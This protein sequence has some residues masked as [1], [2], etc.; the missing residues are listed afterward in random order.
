MTQAFDFNALIAFVAV[1]D[2]ES[3][4]QAAEQLHLTQPAISKRVAALERD[5]DARLF[6][7]IGRGTY[8]T[9]AGRKLLP[10]AR[11]MLR[12]VMDIRRSISNLSGEV[13]GVLNMGTSHHIGLRRLPPLLQKYSQRFPQ[14]KLDIRFMDSE[15]ACAAV[16]QGDLELAVVTLPPDPSAHLALQEVWPD[17]LCFVVGQGHPLAKVR[18]AQLAQLADYPAVL[19]ARGT[20]TREILEQAMQ[21]MDLAIQISMTTNYLETLKMLTSI[22]LGWS[23]LPE[24]MTLD[25]DL[26]VLD[27]QGLRLNRS[28]GIVTH[29]QRSLSNA[30]R[31]MIAICGQ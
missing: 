24:T 29:R 13:M 19:A 8:L 31:E 27:I 16:E 1:A 15:S 5:F 6:D 2:A 4:S 10:R 14:V 11:Q 28:L 22:G 12:E 30:A 9:E 26:A 7:R 21:P 20:Y 23:L 17:P 18:S 3:F 25:G